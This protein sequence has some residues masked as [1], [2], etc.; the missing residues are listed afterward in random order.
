MVKD[1]H[2]QIELNSINVGRL[3]FMLAQISR[4]DVHK[5]TRCMYHSSIPK[6]NPGIMITALAIQLANSMVL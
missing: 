4:D 6:I 5:V 3:F 1:I 2:I